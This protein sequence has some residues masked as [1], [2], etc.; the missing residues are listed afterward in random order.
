MGVWAANEGGVKLILESEIVG[1]LT[2][3]RHKAHVLAA[4]YRLAYPEF[5]VPSHLGFS[6]EIH[7]ICAPYQKAQ[8]AFPP[9]G[10]TSA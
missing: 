3:A 9:L 2:L 7:A 1:E 8:P 10:E 4:S 5:H 6:G